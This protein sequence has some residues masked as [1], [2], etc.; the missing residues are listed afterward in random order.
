MRS[1]R[2]KSST[3]A[4]SF[5]N[6]GLDTTANG[7]RRR[8]RRAPRR[9]SRARCRRCRPAPST[10]R[11]RSSAP[12]MRRPML[13]AAASTY[14]MS[15]LPSSSGRRADRDEL[16]RAVR[17][18]C[19]DVG[20]EAQAPGRDVARDHRLEPRLVDRHA[21][22]V[23][24]RDLARVDVEAQHV[25]ADLG[26]AGA[27]DETDVAGAD[28]RDLHARCSQ[29]AASEALIGG[30]RGH[31]IRGLRD[32]P[33]DDEIVGAAAHRGFRRD[34]ARLVVLRGIGR[35][36]C[37][38]VTS[39]NA[40]AACGAQRRRF[41]RRAHDAVEAARLRQAREPQRVRLRGRRRRRRRAGRRRRGS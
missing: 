40:G 21:A 32:R 30:E 24:D 25:V 29:R 19:V 33:A 37:P 39:L 16:Q 22:V 18:R 17:D 15:A 27:G 3:A 41:L 11:R 5:R 10:C 8:A 20:G 35:D 14:C 7:S 13:R 26:E 38:G 6:S 36:G 2:M 34:D 23:E 12:S 1:G 28:H 31:R 9:S 4:P